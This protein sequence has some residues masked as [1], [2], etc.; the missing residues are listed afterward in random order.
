M[1][2]LLSILLVTMY[3]GTVLQAQQ[4]SEAER[5]I[6]EYLEG[7]SYWRFKYNPEDTTFPGAVSKNDSLIDYNNK[8]FDYMI[9]AGSKQPGLL[10]KQ[11]ALPDDADM[12]VV[13]SDDK[14]L[15]IYSWDTHLGGELHFFN[16]V[17]LYQAAGS[18]RADTIVYGH[19]GRWGQDRGGVYET[20]MTASGDGGKKI[21]LAIYKTEVSEKEQRKTIAAYAIEGAELKRVN[22]FLVKDVPVNSIGY[23]YDYMANYD[24]NKMQEL[25]NVY[26]GKSGKKLYVPVSGANNQLTGEWQVYNFD[27]GK[28]VYEKT[29]K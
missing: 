22:V 24:F 18:V 17:A 7:I 29:E 21:Y 8:L 1:K 4:L 9:T 27:G 11:P 13:S 5:K 6:N 10:R 20:I 23:Q 2:K 28:F 12:T 15:S 3:T 14:K 16:A 25:Q 19:P 26:L